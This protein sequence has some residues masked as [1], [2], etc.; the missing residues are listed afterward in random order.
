MELKVNGRRHEVDVD[1][2]RTLLSVL[3][4]ELNLTGT[5]YGCGEGNCGACTVLIEGDAVR[6]CI[7]PVAA[8]TGRAITTIEGLSAGEELHPVQNAFVRHTAFQCG[9]CTPG[10]IMGAAALLGQNP[11]PSDAEIKAG[12]N[13]HICRCGAYV[14]IIQAVREAASTSGRK[15]AKR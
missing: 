14:R 6:A 15:A 5:K 10:F 12:L 13:G 3:R 7:T 4:H 1:P 11:D 2:E 8:S 9:Y